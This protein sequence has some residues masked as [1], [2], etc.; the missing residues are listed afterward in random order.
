MKVSWS[1]DKLNINGKIFTAKDDIQQVDSSAY[2]TEIVQEQS[3]KSDMQLSFPP[4]SQ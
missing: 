1:L 4:T 3:Q 2:K